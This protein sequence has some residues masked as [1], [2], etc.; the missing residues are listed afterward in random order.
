M[1][2]SSSLHR[3]TSYNVC[4]TKLLRIYEIEGAKTCAIEFRSFSKTAG[5]TGVRCGLIVVPD[6]LMGT[7]ASGEKYSLNKPWNRRTTT[8]FNGAS[9]PAQRAAAAVCP[10][11]GWKE[12]QEISY[13]FV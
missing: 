6:E 2:S 12:T 4:Y 1:G 8:T 13:N 11:Q 9:Y 10:E 7:T 5:F 3:I